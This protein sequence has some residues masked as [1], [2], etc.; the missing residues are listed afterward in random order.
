M[1]RSH[2]GPGEEQ[3]RSS[4]CSWHSFPFQSW[5]GSCRWTGIGCA[6]G[7]GAWAAA[8]PAARRGEKIS[9]AFHD[10]AL[11][12]GPS[13]EV[14]PDCSHP[15]TAD[16]PGVQGTAWKRV[17]Q[18]QHCPHMCPQA[19]TPGPS[20][21]LSPQCATAG[22]EG[23]GQGGLPGCASEARSQGGRRGACG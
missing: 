20:P 14:T 1:L 21:L 10:T 4:S 5:G 7:A 22:T 23:S 18:V 13:Q 3:G 6:G 15:L 19:Q 9:D 12:T 16:S 2:R 11:S 17:L 8:G